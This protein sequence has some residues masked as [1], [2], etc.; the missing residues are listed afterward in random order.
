M[1]ELK[2]IHPLKDSLPPLRFGEPLAVVADV[3]L[4]TPWLE[5]PN[6]LGRRLSELDGEPEIALSFSSRESASSGSA[7]PAGSGPQPAPPRAST[8]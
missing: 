2:L 6:S 3:V 7:S 5:L 4:E 8:K 1:T